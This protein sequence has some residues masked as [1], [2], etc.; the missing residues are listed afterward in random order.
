MF[1]EN[2]GHLQPGLLSTVNELPEKQRE[3][4]K[5]SWAE[6][7]YREFHCRIDEKAF[8]AL[9]VDFPSRP[10]APINEIVSLEFLKAANDW[11]DEEMYERYLFDVQ[12]RYALGLDSLGETHLTL[13]TVYN[14]RARLSKHMRETGRN[15]L[16]QAF[17][18]VTDEQLE[19]YELKT[20]KQRMDSTMLASNIRQMGR[21]QLLVEV[22]QQTSRM[23]TEDEQAKHAEVLG[24]YL[25]G[26]AGKYVYQLKKKEQAQ[27]IY[28]IGVVMQRL[29]AELKDAHGS[30]PTYQL[31]E[32]VFG[33][34]FRVKETEIETK[35]PKELT[36]SSLQSP[37]DPEA[38]YREKRGESHQG[39]VANVTETCHPENKLQLITKV[40]TAP[41]TTDDSH[42]LAEAVP[43]LKERMELEEVLT[44][45][46]FG[47][48]EADLVLH[49]HQVQQTQT[50]IRGPKTDPDKLY[51]ADFE[52]KFDQEGNPSRITCQH[53]QTVPVN[54]TCRKKGFVAL[55]DP[56]VCKD[57]PFW[58]K[59]QCPAEPGKRD[60]RHRLRFTLTKA[61]AA[62]RHR[63]SHALK[64]E[65]GNL[66]AAVEATVRS[67]KHPFPA[68]RLPV[69]GQFRVAC[70]VIG[71]AAVSNVRRIH[72]YQQSK[73]R[74][75]KQENAASEGM[76]NPPEQVGELFFAFANTTFA[77]FRRLAQT[78]SAL[79][80]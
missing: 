2:L 32:R 74:A 9:Y 46:T 24:P 1:K 49:E 12:S 8:A 15:L 47:G 4:L 14:F 27:H 70:M 57:C 7:F 55:F 19:A 17:E 22:L 6:V 42:L 73:R 45:A 51:L 72:R 80:A 3:I 71:S 11:T 44:D 43:N 5:N 62:D 48:P 10:N 33:E 52:I 68:G 35:E 50:A 76:K 77:A 65:A 36:G 67:V 20:G 38:T 78:K 37:H 21:L 60:P 40:Q 30:D 25:V 16:D 23:L 34:H 54:L 31:L 69:R 28:Q 79:L 26:P 39:Y 29:L 66:R 61:R 56:Q 18:Q 63:R 41:N 58:E 59:Q 53:D 64:K 75:E 13:R